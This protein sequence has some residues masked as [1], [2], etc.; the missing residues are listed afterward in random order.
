MS[1]LTGLIGYPVAHSK[2]PAIHEYWIQ[3]QGIDAE[4]KLYTTPPQRVRQVVKRLRDKGAR[5]F[6]VTVPHKLAVMEYLDEIDETARDI[7]AVN[8]V[9]FK[10]G[11]A[12][13]SNTDGYGFITNLRE[14]VG[15]L[16][17][18][19]SKVVIL[20]SGGASRAVLLALIEAGAKE[21]FLTNRTH[22]S[23]QTLSSSARD[24]KKTANIQVV[25]WE[26]RA[27]C[28]SE[29]SLLV[30]ATSLGMEHQPPLVL[31][32]NQL[33]TTALV[34]D[35]VYAPLKTDLLKQAEARGNRTVDGLGM[36]LYQA[37][38]AFSLWHGVLPAVTPELRARVQG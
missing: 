3:Q 19:L 2:S 13:G 33:P 20:G 30:N 12:I 32:I 27:S 36:L 6:N 8:T 26:E 35:I 21:I 38:K 10:N 7:G 11:K 23:A 9:T 28:L 29:A 18:Y 31:D 24:I 1:I 5:G 4:Y 25:D 17:P 34:H 15:D 22:E 16:S 37:Q 14:G